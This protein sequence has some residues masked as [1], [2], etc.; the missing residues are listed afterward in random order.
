ML[1]SQQA[2]SMSRSAAA[3][4]AGSHFISFIVSLSFKSSLSRDETF[5]GKVAA[6]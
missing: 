6:E 3:V 5:A 2:S 4:C 1:M